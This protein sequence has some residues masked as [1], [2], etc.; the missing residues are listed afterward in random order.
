[1]E[2]FAPLK[3]ELYMKKNIIIRHMIYGFLALIIGLVGIFV[4]ISGIKFLITAKQMTILEFYAHIS[5]SCIV[6]L[7]AMRILLW[8]AWGMYEVIQITWADEEGVTCKILGKVV[9]HLSWDEIQ[10]WGVGRQCCIT[11]KCYR[12]LPSGEERFWHKNRETM[13]SA[14]IYFSTSKLQ[15]NEKESLAVECHHR[16]GLLIIEY[17][18]KRYIESFNFA[19]NKYVSRKNSEETITKNN[20]ASK[21]NDEKPITSYVDIDYGCLFLI[22]SMIAGGSIVELLFLG[23][24]YDIK[25]LFITYNICAV[26]YVWRYFKKVVVDKSGIVYR[27]NFFRKH[28]WKWK[29]IYECAVL[30]DHFTT[31][32]VSEDI[33]KR[34][35]YFTKK[36]FNYEQKN[37]KSF[38]IRHFRKKDIIMVK[39]S[40]ELYWYLKKLGVLGIKDNNIAANLQH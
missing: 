14:Y 23:E 40:E 27:D 13:G 38:F 2:N 11:N 31:G 39:Y 25:L 4:L 1:M 22:G 37:M 20:K 21:I 12:I 26:W 18:E 30:R 8:C 34:Y 15:E 6:I 10:D 7:S 32:R 33:E 5:F 28:E 9:Q 3:G 17:S 35:I 24:V 36:P 19:K 16:K 29:E